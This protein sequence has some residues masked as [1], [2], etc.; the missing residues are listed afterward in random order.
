MSRSGLV[1]GRLLMAGLLS[2]AV[3][4]EAQGALPGSEQLDSSIFGGGS[5]E[6]TGF[7]S[8]RFGMTEAE[9]RAAITR[10]FGVQDK[11]VTVAENPIERTKV[12]SLFAPDLVPRGGRAQVTYVMGFQWR[13][14]IQVTVTWSN[15]SDARITPQVLTANSELLQAHLRRGGYRSETVATDVP[16]G[17]NGLVVFRGAD[18][19]G[20]MTQLTLT[21]TTEEDRNGNR[22]LT[23][24]QLQL[25]YV[26]DPVRPDVFKLKPGLF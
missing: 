6:V 22:I 18:R 12:I 7:R 25:F 8:A 16:L 4:A 11:D 21:G 17:K 2:A 3:M 24:K 15:A 13:R 5:T 9:V 10:D 20:H 19:K 23:P 14:L 1:I 26:A